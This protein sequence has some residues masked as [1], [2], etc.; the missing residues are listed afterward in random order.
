[1]EKTEF[2][3]SNGRDIT[4]HATSSSKPIKLSDVENIDVLKRELNLLKK[5][6]ERMNKSDRESSLKTQ[7]RER[8]IAYTKRIAQL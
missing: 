8:V 4:Y 6:F 2:K 1:M 3:Y 5:K 7:V